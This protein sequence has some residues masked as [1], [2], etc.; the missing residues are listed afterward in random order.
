M[1]G[2]ML[3]AKVGELCPK[4][5][6]GRGKTRTPEVQVFHRNTLTDYR[7]LAKHQREQKIDH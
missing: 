7:K 3:T 6:G 1:P 5:K 4:E 2:M